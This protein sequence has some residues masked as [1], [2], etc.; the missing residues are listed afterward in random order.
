MKTDTPRS[1]C[2]EEIGGA[3]V[4]HGPSSDRVYLMKCSFTQ[5][6]HD[7]AVLER[8]VREKGYGKIFAK[9]PAP[10]SAVFLAAGYREEA[11]IPSYFGMDACLFMCRY[12]DP[13]RSEMSE[14]DRVLC[15]EVLTLAVGKAPASSTLAAGYALRPLSRD[16]CPSMAALYRNVFET[17]PFPIH[18]TA[19]LEKTMEEH[20]AYYGVFR[21]QELCAVSSA[22]MDP[23]T[24]SAEMT[25]FA[26]K[27]GETGKGF[28][29]ALLAAMEQDMP[30][31]GITTF[32]TIARA[33]SHGMNSS[34]ARA[35]YRYGGTLVNNTDIFGRIESMNVWY[36]LPDKH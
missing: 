17:Y 25:D 21:A 1:D 7:L 10:W 30:R 2:I 19:Y 33:F 28:A 35:G 14:D 13:S 4:H 31:Q 5:P 16:D 12:P 34:F 15:E 23:S 3:M 29:S 11:V 20:V 8:L 27:E 18:D 26:T 36:K 22:E 9:I 6:E 24:S 32:Y